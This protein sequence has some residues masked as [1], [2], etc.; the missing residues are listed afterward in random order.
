[1]SDFRLLS[2][3][4]LFL[5]LTNLACSSSRKPSEEADDARDGSADTGSEEAPDDAA[6]ADSGRTDAAG[7][8][9]LLE[10]HCPNKVLEP[11]LKEKCDDGNYFDDDGCTRYCE[12]SCEDDEECDDLNDCNGIE[13]CG[14][15][16]ACEKGEWLEDG[17]RC[18]V[19]KSCFAGLCRDD[20]CGDGVMNEDLGEDC[21]DGNNIDDDACSNRCTYGCTSEDDC[22]DGDPCAGTT[23]CD[24]DSHECSGPVLDDETICQT[25]QIRDGWCMKHVCVPTKCGNNTK[26][27]KEQCDEGKKNGTAESSC[28]VDCRIVACGNASIE[29]S[30]QCDDGGNVNMDSCDKECKAEIFFRWT[31]MEIL[32]ELAPEWCVHAGKNAFAKAFPGE[33]EIMGLRTVDVLGELNDAMGAPIENCASNRVI[34]I[35]DL[36]DPSFKTSDDSVKVAVHSGQLA[37]GQACTKPNPVDMQFDLSSE[38]IE[39]GEPTETIS[40]IQRPGLVQSKGPIFIPAQSDTDIRAGALHDFMF[41]WQFDTE[42]LSTPPTMERDDG[43]E[44]IELPETMGVNTTATEPYHAAGRLCAA[45]SIKGMQDSP[46]MEGSEEALCCSSPES[47]RGVRKYTTC[48]EDDPEAECDNTADLVANG[49]VICI[50]INASGFVS[51]DCGGG[52]FKGCVGNPFEVVHPSPPDIDTDGID[53]ND[54]LSIV[55]GVEGV[56]VRSLGVKE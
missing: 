35:L 41:L 55:I 33:V 20:V 11:A 12:F 51:P 21:D 16:H 46:I 28:S 48:P 6:V 19:N 36:A 34:Q 14:S 9:G 50:D 39:A 26:E 38:G 2:I 30:E 40:A 37:P 53:G 23:T 45:M 15:D 43:R 47:K 17:Q 18:D 56:R 4:F 32:R 5:L 22:T 49:C 44:A 29:G 25:T 1:M 24:K 3:L 52:E 8:A 54:A 10:G 27:G 13:T 7:Q 31:R 42:N